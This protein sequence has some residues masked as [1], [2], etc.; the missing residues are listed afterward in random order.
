[1]LTKVIYIDIEGKSYPM[2]FSLACLKHMDSIQMIASKV[3]K[4]QSISDSAEVIA[5]MLSAMI[6]SGCYY[7]NEMH[8]TNYPNSPAENGKIKPLSEEKI[9]YLIPAD[10]K[11]LK[12]VVQKIQ[13]CVNVSNAKSINAVNSV[14]SK[15]KKKKH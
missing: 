4:N 2:T 11:S 15:K 7:C 3:Q 12:Y 1:M 5:R 9:L 10:E 6:T 13:L 14:G 8:L